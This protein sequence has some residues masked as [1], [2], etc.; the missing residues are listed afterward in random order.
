[1][2]VI[3]II[4]VSITMGMSVAAA[5]VGKNRVQTYMLIAPAIT[6][7]I[8]YVSLLLYLTQLIK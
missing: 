4:A 7:V 6:A 8:S 3:C 1:M 2:L 5:V